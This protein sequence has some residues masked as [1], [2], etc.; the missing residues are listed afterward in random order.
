MQNSDWYRGIGGWGKVLKAAR[1]VLG[2]AL[3]MPAAA[4]SSTPAERPTSKESAQAVK[5]KQ[6]PGH[7]ELPEESPRTEGQSIPRRVTAPAARPLRAGFS[8]IQVNVDGAQNNILGDAANEPS[9]A[10][11]PTDPSRIVIGWREFPTVSNSHREAGYAYSHDGGATWTF[12]GTLRPGEFGSDPVLGVNSDGDFYYYSLQPNRGPGPFACYMYRSTD[13]GLTWTDSYGFGGDKQWFTIDRTGFNSNGNIYTVWNSQFGCCAGEFGRSFDGGSNF[14]NPVVMP[15]PRLKWGTIAVGP[16]GRVHFAGST[17]DG[18]SHLYVRSSNAAFGAQTTV[19]DRLSEPDLG[20]IEQA[21]VIPN[22]AGLLGQVWIDLDRSGGPGHGNIYILSS[23]DPPGTDPAEARFVRSIDGGLTW[24]APISI[25]D[26]A[27]GT[28]AWQWFATMSV[29][30]NGRLDAVW[31]DTRDDPTVT[32]SVLYHSYSIDGGLTWSANEA[33]TP[34]F[35]HGL[36]YPGQSKLGDYYHMVSDNGAAH[37][38]YAATFNGEQ[39]VFYLRIPAD[40]NNNGVDDDEDVLVGGLAD[41]NGNLIPDSC[42]SS[43]DCNGNLIADICEIGAGEEDCDQNLILDSCEPSSDCNSNGAEDRCEIIDGASGD[44]NGNGIPDDC[45]IDS[46]TSLDDNGTGVPDECE[47]ACCDCDVCSETTFNG[48]VA[49]GGAFLGAGTTCAEAV[50]ETPNDACEFATVLPSGTTAST[51]FVNKCATGGDPVIDVCDGTFA[52]IGADLWYE[53]TPSCCGTMTVSLCDATDFDAV[54]SVYGRH[55]FCL[56]PGA[57]DVADLCG[58]DNCGAVSG[59]GFVQLPVDVDECFLIRVGGWSGATGNGQLEI[60]VACDPDD[61]G[62]GLCDSFDNC[63]AASNAEQLDADGDGVGD[64]CDPCPATAGNDSDGD[65]ICADIDNCPDVANANQ[66][67]DNGNGVG[68]ACEPQVVFVRFDAPGANN[69]T[70]WTDAY[71]DLQAGLAAAAALTSPPTIEVWVAAG[72]YLPSAEREPGDPRS[73]AFSPAAGVNMYGGFSGTETRRDQRDPEVNETI[74]SG[75]LAE[76]DGGFPGNNAENAYNVLVFDFVGDPTTVD[77]FTLTRGNA[78]NP[79]NVPI[80]SIGGGGVAF[81]RALATN[82]LRNCIVR[83][84]VGLAG[85]GAVV[86]G[87]PGAATLSDVSDCLF[88]NN[89]GG[90]GGGMFIGSNRSFSITNS[91][92]IGNAAT[93][94]SNL[95]GGLYVLFPVPNGV[96]VSNVEFRDNFA[97]IDGGAV[98]ADMGGRSMWLRNCTIVQNSAQRSGGV[99]NGSSITG[100]PGVV[101]IVNSILWQNTDSGGNDQSAQVGGGVGGTVAVNFTNVQGLTGSLGGLG[102]TNLEPRFVDPPENLRLKPNSP[103]IDRGIDGLVVTA[104]DL[105]GG[106]RRTD[107]DEDGEAEVDLGA[108]ELAGT[109]DAPEAVTIAETGAGLSRYLGFDVPGAGTASALRVTML[110]LLT[111]ASG[112]NTAGTPDFA[113]FE[114]QARWVGP[115]TEYQEGQS[116]AAGT[117]FVAELQC[118]P[119]YEDWAAVL[120][121]APL[122]VTGG[123]ILPSSMFEIERYG[124]GCGGIESSCVDVSDFAITGTTQWGDIVEPFEPPSTLSQ[125]NIADIL[126]IVDKFLGLPSAPTKAAAKLQPN[127]PD[128]GLNVN[129]NDILACVDSFLGTAYPFEGPAECPSER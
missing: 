82:H 100:A 87:A 32:T 69:G 7:L 35:N 116:A 127:V 129:I 67:D 97:A 31:N 28:D 50:C 121:G 44:C 38:A 114:G 15:D 2:V 85:G 29:A 17:L 110:E 119:H 94:G 64:A 62:D 59:P 113:S 117:L 5:R 75:D 26:D 86:G 101:N 70:S 79:G 41:C 126:T 8:S 76:D 12:P 111:S 37:L 43:A 77:G 93:N 53:F 27:P 51:G 118:E 58:D 91:R 90:G 88:E 78:D 122:F 125:P 36:G 73:V 57:D 25:N 89:I 80:G 83:E 81:I 3:A 95:G 61:D 124:P 102:N 112:A 66:A 103:L 63:P 46:G 128:A 54:V 84:N 99:Y 106:S 68:N 98:Y 14:S 120:G 56:C 9:I 109:R 74:L 19:F 115:P 34:A 11:D 55:D 47:G 92:F 21:G 4:Q 52:P 1:V 104:T 105:A 16:S 108:F 22:P 13:G 48:C 39:D 23:V 6:D 42:E 45:D 24:S 49:L 123:G 40:C 65:G 18:T 72:T 96:N 20:G 33:V 107:G 60:D 30:P 71:V 10:I